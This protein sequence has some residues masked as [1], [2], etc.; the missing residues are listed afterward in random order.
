MAD[1]IICLIMKVQK[2]LNKI[3]YKDITVLEAIDMKGY[4][5]FFLRKTTDSNYKSI[6]KTVYENI[7][8]LF[9]QFSKSPDNE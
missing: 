5:V 6:S 2:I 8:K 3:T 1:R 4:A 9:L 7:I